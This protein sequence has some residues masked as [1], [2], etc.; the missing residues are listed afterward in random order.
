MLEVID[1]GKKIVEYYLRLKE[2]YEV[3]INEKPDHRELLVLSI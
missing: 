1:V 3:I 2:V